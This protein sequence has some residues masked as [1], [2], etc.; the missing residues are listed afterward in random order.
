METIKTGCIIQFGYLGTHSH[1]GT[2]TLISDMVSA[3]GYIAYQRSTRPRILT[4]A[5]EK[6]PDN[7]HVQM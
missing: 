7:P 4:E 1:G 6:V 5:P 2:G 3:A